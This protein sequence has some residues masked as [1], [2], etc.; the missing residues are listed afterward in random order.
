MK[1][2]FNL[3]IKSSLFNTQ[4]NLLVDFM[5]LYENQKNYIFRK[6]N[7]NV[8]ISKEEVKKIGEEQAKEKAK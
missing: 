8:F 5:K 1:T 4:E 2:S 6:N 3:N 7:T